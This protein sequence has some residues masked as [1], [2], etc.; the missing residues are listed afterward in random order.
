MRTLNKPRMAIKSV[1][2]V[3]MT[4]VAL[5]LSLFSF[6]HT[7]V[8]AAGN[9][10]IHLTGGSSKASEIKN[11][12]EEVNTI[13]TNN[14]VSTFVRVHT[15]SQG[16]GGI[17]VGSG[18]VVVE[19]LMTN[20]NGYTSETKKAVM[21]TALEGVANSSLPQQMR[22]KLYNF[23]AEQ[24]SATSALVRQLSQDVSADYAT[25]YTWFKP[26]TGGISTVFGILTLSIFILLAL[27]MVVDLS[28][29]ALPFLKAALDRTDGKK[30][31]IVSNEAFKAVQQAEQD[32]TGNKQA[33]LIYF[34]NKSFQLCILMICLIYLVGG[35]IYTLVSWI[36]DSLQ[37]AL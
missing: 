1:L 10:I 4:G 18:E 12:F 8:F 3:L 26:F 24:D 13:C 17:E 27:T 35:K 11:I 31:K 32:N 37:G 15:S 21:S 28:Y 34:K 36:V 9:P 7:V 6:S 2:T 30:P 20:Y 25:A 22:L 5:L 29:I 19:L 16:N 23:I 14:G 33:V